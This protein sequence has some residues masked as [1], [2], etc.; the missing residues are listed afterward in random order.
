MHTHIHVSAKSIARAVQ[1]IGS[2]FD[3][4]GSGIPVFLLD[5]FASEGEDTSFKTVVEIGSEDDVLVLVA[6]GKLCVC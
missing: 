2:L 4:F 3:S 1:Y 5:C 6:V